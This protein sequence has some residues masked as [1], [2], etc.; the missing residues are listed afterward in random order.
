[1]IEFI[2]TRTTTAPIETVLHALAD[3]RAIADYVWAC[4]RIEVVGLFLDTERN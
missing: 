3:H 4:R 1:M 2:L